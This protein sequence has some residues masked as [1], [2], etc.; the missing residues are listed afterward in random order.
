VFEHFRNERG[1]GVSLVDDDQEWLV[2]LAQ[3]LQV[4]GRSSCPHES[5][6]PAEVHEIPA[7][8]GSESG[9]PLA[10]WPG[11]EQCGD[12]SLLDAPLGQEILFGPGDELDDLEIRL[13]DQGTS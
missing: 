8:F 11:E 5:G 4:L 10:T 1:P 9:L 3:R 6:D 13:K 2:N 7:E 12:A